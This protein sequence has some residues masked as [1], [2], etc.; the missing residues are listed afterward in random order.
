MTQLR[1][2]L[3]VFGSWEALAAEYDRRLPILM[4]HHIGPPRPGSYPFLTVSPESFERQ[5]KWLVWLGFV[6]ISPSQWFRWRRKGTGLPKRSILITFDDA[7][8]DIADY[9]LPVLR[10]FGFSGA[11]YVVSG[12]FGGTNTWDEADRC[13]TLKLMDATHIRFWAERG[14]EFGAHSRTH[15][16][17]RKLS[18]GDCRAEIIGSKNDLADLLGA[19]VISFAYPY[20]N[21]MTACA[22]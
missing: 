19:P 5:I 9:A 14:I 3:A 13:G 4:Y 22:P 21:T 16:D 12:R 11:V 15:A 20:A 7:Y 17:L 8:V 18:E 1:S 6:G 2:A 10:R